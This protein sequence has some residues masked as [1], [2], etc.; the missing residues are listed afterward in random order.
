VSPS[1]GTTAGGQSL[2]ITGSGFQPDATVSL[3]GLTAPTVSVTSSTSLTLTTPHRPAGLVAISVVNP[4]VQTGTKVNAYE[5]RQPATP[6]RLSVNRVGGSVVLTW[7]ANGQGA[8]VVFKSSQA[9]VWTDGSILT[10]T[11]GTTFTDAGGAAVPG[12]LFYQVD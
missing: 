9:G 11:T 2:T 4:G 5:F 10:T 6:V 7:V 3:G 12:I 1:F 8:Y